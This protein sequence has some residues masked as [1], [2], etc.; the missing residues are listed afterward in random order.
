MPP[1]P[2]A[3]YLVEGL[4]MTS[5]RLICEAGMLWITSLKLLLI[6]AELRPLSN[7]L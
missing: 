1:T 2:S 4:V 3:S 6:V 7:I 5:M